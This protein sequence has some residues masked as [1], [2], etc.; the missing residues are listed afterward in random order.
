MQVSATAFGD[1]RVGESVEALC[2]LRQQR[3]STDSP[4]I[5]ASR[6]AARIQNNPHIGFIILTD[7]VR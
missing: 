2:C 3:A 1:D 7:K 5:L 6:E 4:T